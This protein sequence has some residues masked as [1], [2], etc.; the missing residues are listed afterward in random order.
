VQQFQT[1]YGLKADGMIGAETRKVI[2]DLLK[3]S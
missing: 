1:K 3:G 2:N